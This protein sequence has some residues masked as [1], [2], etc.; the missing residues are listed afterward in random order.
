VS[1]E[2]GRDDMFERFE[3]FTYAMKTNH[4]AEMTAIRIQNTFLVDETSYLMF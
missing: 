1:L 4:C 2:R 3:I